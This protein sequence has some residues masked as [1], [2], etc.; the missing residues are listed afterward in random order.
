MHLYGP[1]RCTVVVL[2]LQDQYIKAYAD[3]GKAKLMGRTAELVAQVRDAA[4]TAKGSAKASYSSQQ[5][6]TLRHPGHDAVLYPKCMVL[7]L[8]CVP[9][10]TDGHFFAVNVMVT[11]VAGAG[12]D[13]SYM[14]VLEVSTAPGRGFGNQCTPTT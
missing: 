3:T 7:L 12:M 6:F 1:Q 13:S 8:P 10:H 5:L 9:Q 4:A 11:R 14:G 2:F